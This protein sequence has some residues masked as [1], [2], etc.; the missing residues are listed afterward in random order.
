MLLHDHRD[1]SSQT[2]HQTDSFQNEIQE[3]ERT[4]QNKFC[5]ITITVWNSRVFL[6]MK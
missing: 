3:Y 4:I 1:D 2:D 6:V 5:I